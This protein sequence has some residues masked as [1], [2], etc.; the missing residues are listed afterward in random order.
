MLAMLDVTSLSVCLTSGSVKE[1][2]RDGQP[3]PAGCAIR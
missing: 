1:T 3:L 2:Q